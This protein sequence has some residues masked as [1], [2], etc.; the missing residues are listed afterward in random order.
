MATIKTLKETNDSEAAQ[1][2][3]TEAE[4]AELQTVMQ[5]HQQVQ[6]TK[7]I[8]LYLAKR[9]TSIQ[10]DNKQARVETRR[11]FR[12]VRGEYEQIK[13]TSIRAF[14]GSEVFIRSAEMKSRAAYSWVTDI[15]RGDNDLPWDLE[16]TSVPT[17][18]DETKQAIE[19]EIMRRGQEM[20]QQ[21]LMQSQQSGQPIDSQ[22]F[23]KMLNDW[24]QVAEQKAVETINKDAKKRCDKAALQI[25]DNNQ[26]GGW[27]QAFKD[28]LW[29]FIRCKAGIIKGPILQK[30]KK[31]AWQ[32]NPETGDF[33]LGTDEIV[34]ND[35]YCVS[36]FNFFPAR[37][38]SSVND[39]DLFELHELTRQS[40]NDLVG[41]PNYNEAEIKTVL[42]KLHS[43]ALKPRWLT[44]DDEVETR[45]VQ[46]E[47]T[48]VGQSVPATTIAGRMPD[49]KIQALEFYGSVPGAMLL[50]WG[51][52]ADGIVATQEYQ[53]NCWK[54][55]DH[56]IKAVINPDSLGRKPYH[57]S[58]WAKNPFWILG[59]G[60]IEFAEPIEDILNSI[61]RALQNNIAIASG[62][63]V[64]I[65]SDRCD[66]KT[67]IYPWKVWS[68]TTSQMKDGPAV[69][70][71]QPQ[72]HTGELIQAY[73]F[74][75]KLLDEMTVPAYAQ[76]ASQSGVTAGTATVFTQLL[77]AASRS[78]KA[79][80]AN[81]DDDII[82]PYIQMCYDNLMKFT[83]DEELKGD[84]S[85]VAKGVSGLLAKE[86]E[87]QRKVEFLQVVANPV[88][89]QTLGA[90]NIGY[91]LAQI[92]KSNNLQLP[93]MERLEGTPSLEELLTKMNTQSAGLDPN[94]VNGQMA[95]GGTPPNAQN[96]T[97]TG[98][99]AGSPN[100]QQ[101]A[102][103]GQ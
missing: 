49:E 7:K 47:K 22:G 74:F 31:Q 81:I 94:Q 96:T 71:W 41:V 70:F 91:V 4:L 35:V 14:K 33:F 65:N 30:R 102:Q 26:E 79:V 93:D 39:G 67:P 69:S 89:A 20:Q 5:Q 83:D 84:A 38:I 3:A 50:E 34:A 29:Y 28:F 100:M 44:I 75:G 16:P 72:M 6:V 92:A 101:P 2:A 62:P 9:W 80:V 52:S 77:A 86:Q 36:P 66:N 58:S 53:A 78:I 11:I 23:A 10:Q 8:V 85:V 64:E 68:S 15:Y 59:E 21:L 25:R 55:G 12:R 13:L 63:Q 56:V 90:K 54:I 27:N 24:Q 73:E 1:K 60:L 103:I 17:L 97:A 42:S 37:G 46:F 48:P 43:G 76:G 95:S 18:P 57:V 19:Q 98:A 40:L 99:P 82:A 32:V 51:L 87:A 88:Y 61:A 45:N